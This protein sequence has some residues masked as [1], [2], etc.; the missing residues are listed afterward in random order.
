MGTSSFSAL[1]VAMA[2]V[3]Q[4]E[5]DALD[6]A[7]AQVDNPQNGS[8]E[9]IKLCVVLAGGTT[10]EIA[11][12]PSECI[13]ALRAGVEK[14]HSLPPA[15]L[16]KLFQ[17]GQLLHDDIPIKDIDCT[18]PIFGTISRET[19]LEV[20]LQAAGLYAGYQNMLRSA[21]AGAADPK[22]ITVGPV[23][24]IL[25]VLE[26][27]GGQAPD[28][29]HLSSGDVDGALKFSGADGDL[30]LPSIDASALL[31]AVGA[32][33]FASVT[34]SIEL[35]SD[36][37]NAGLGVVLEASPLMDS[38]VDEHGLPMYVYNGYGISNNKKQNAVK[39][40][41]GMRGG[42][43]RVEGLGG[44]GNQSIGFTPSNWSDSGHRYHTL[45]LTLSADGE[46]EMCIKGTNAGE[47]WR[48]PWKR[49]LT[50]GRYFPAIYAWL[51]LGSSRCPLHIRNIGLRVQMQ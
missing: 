11:M 17:D 9:S 13:I 47:V 39:F 48:K 18:Q 6:D 40:H 33:K 16:L 30:L 26:E 43:L 41:P 31:S 29:K 3:A 1:P 14:Q 22:S 27:M 23:P 37:F 20:L 12:N 38:S 50:E 49:Q 7:P 35:N 15:C 36:A 42:Q 46:N 21:V 8:D 19:K 2:D 4:Q 24:T 45:E 51:D 44:W 25:E 28:L 34:V 32:E 5:H 10:F